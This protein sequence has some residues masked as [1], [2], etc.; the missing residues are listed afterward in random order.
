MVGSEVMDAVA[1][2]I[3]TFVPASM[4]VFEGLTDSVGVWVVTFPG[5]EFPPFTACFFIAED[6]DDDDDVGVWGVTE[7]A[8]YKSTSS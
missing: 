4:V 7:S 2:D 1:Q 3:V 6:D 5:S 8:Q